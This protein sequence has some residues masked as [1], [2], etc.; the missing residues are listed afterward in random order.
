[1][2]VFFDPNCGRNRADAAGIERRAERERR[3]RDPNY[4]RLQDEVA[5]LDR[6]RGLFG[7][8][9]PRNR[10]LRLTLRSLITLIVILS[11]ILLPLSLFWLLTLLF[12]G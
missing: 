7:F 1:M 11:L 9:E 8:R 6:R 10:L 3:Q 2:S 4:A 12:P 5:D